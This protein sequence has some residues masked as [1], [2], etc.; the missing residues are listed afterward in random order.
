MSDLNVERTGTTGCGIGQLHCSTLTQLSVGCGKC[1]IWCRTYSYY[2]C[3]RSTITGLSAISV[4]WRYDYICNGI[5][6]A[7][8]SSCK[9]WDG[10]GRTTCCNTYRRII[11]CP[12]VSYCTTGCIAGEANCSNITSVTSGNIRSSDN[13]CGRINRDRKC[14]GC[15]RTTVCGW[16]NTDRCRYR[17]RC[18]IDRSE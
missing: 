1:C 3:I 8:I 14:Y 17:S 5:C 12:G 18:S 4:D 13:S 9:R 2:K 10:A 15:T 7:C 11:I 16:R 6:T